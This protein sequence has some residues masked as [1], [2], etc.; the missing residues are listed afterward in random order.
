MT[1][2][3]IKRFLAVLGLGLLFISCSKFT[4]E[5]IEDKNTNSDVQV[6]SIKGSVN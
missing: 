5:K 2:Y 4:V 3:Y 6:F 1:T